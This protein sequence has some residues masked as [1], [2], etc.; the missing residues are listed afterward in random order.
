MTSGL[1]GSLHNAHGKINLDCM[2]SASKM[3]MT[4]SKSET[5]DDTILYNQL[6]GLNTTSV[7]IHIYWTV[8]SRV[9]RLKQYS[10]ILFQIEC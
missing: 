2:I 6:N 8:Q 7:H 1:C 5:Q 4:F 10:F 9:I 3:E